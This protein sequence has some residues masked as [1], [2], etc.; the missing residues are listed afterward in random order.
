MGKTYSLAPR[1]EFEPIPTGDYTMRFMD[2]KELVQE[3]DH[4][5]RKKGEA[6][7]RFI[8]E[9][10]V[11]G[12]E[13]DSRQDS[14]D[15]PKTFSAKSKFVRIAIALGIVDEA[16]AI[17][18]GAVIDWDHAL[19]KQCTGSI[20]CKP[21]ASNPSEWTDRIEQYRPLAVGPTR[22]NRTAPAPAKPVD[23]ED[24]PF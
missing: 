4:P 6:Y 20:V 3:Q 5:F 18:G 14:V 19:G 7:L 22:K 12:S 13:P 9:I 1:V 10:T 16:A 23:D 15:I 8:W 2:W 24:V 17:D 11:P 21:K